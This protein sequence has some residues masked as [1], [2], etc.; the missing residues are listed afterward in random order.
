MVIRR[1]ERI[2][3]MAAASDILVGLLKSGD[4]A[5]QVV[6]TIRLDAIDPDPNQPRRHFDPIR[7]HELADS[8]ISV[9]QHQP[10]ILIR[11]GERFRIHVGERRWRASRLAGL[12]TFRALV[13]ATA[14]EARAARIAEIVENEQRDDLTVCELIEGVRALQGDGLKNVE[15]AAALSKSP[16]RISEL[17]ALGDAPGPLA[18]LVDPLGLDLSYQLLRLW[19][20][21]PQ[22]TLDFLAHMPIEH[23]SRVTIALIGQAL[24]DGAAVEPDR[25]L[26]SPARE[27]TPGMGEGASPRVQW[28]TS[29]ASAD[30]RPGVRSPTG[31]RTAVS[32]GSPLVAHP[33]HGEG[34][35][36]F[37]HDAPIDHF[38]VRFGAGKPV[39]LR[40]DRRAVRSPRWSRPPR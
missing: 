8:L 39:V 10:I 31:D 14:P 30:D 27:G 2:A 5:P 20:A 3:R 22:L 24:S 26:K 21:A 35:V 4:D 15:I 29:R 36:V 37:G 19:R 7:L 40:A 23:I 17:S 34:H 38:A 28:P 6:E 9:G 32:S 33:V 25:T 12:T 18:S 13:R 16:G 1:D 11:T